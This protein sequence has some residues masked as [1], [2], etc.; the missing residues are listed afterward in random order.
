MGAW[1]LPG[2]SAVAPVV[3]VRW[4]GPGTATTDERKPNRLEVTLDAGEMIT[5]VGCG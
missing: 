5:A 3:N 1:D 2:L 4:V